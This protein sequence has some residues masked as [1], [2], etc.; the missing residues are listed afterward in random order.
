M[1]GFVRFYINFIFVNV[2]KRKKYLIMNMCVGLKRNYYV[3]NNKKY[4][5]NILL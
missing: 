3:F 4:S 5:C 2:S 1:F